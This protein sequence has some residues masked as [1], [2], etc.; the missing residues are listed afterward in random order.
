[1]NEFD[2]KEAFRRLSDYIDRELTV[3]EMEA[4]RQ[5]LEKCTECAEEFHF[6]GNVVRCVKEKLAR[7]DLPC[8]LLDQLRAA[9]DAAGPKE[10]S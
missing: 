10:K 4:V 1:M 9:L 5:H 2:C 7:I 8:D 6:E 3:D